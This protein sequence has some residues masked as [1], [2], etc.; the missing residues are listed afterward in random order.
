MD[1]KILTY[2]SDN[3]LASFMNK[4]KWREL[5]EAFTSHEEFEPKVRLKYR[6]DGNLESGFALQDWEWIKFGGSS[7]IEWM[8]RDPIKRVRQ[9]QL[10]KDKDYDF[11]DFVESTLESLNISY[12]KEGDKYKV[13]GY[14]KTQPNFVYTNT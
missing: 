11:C 2:I 9:G 8:D 10:I 13:W 5:A 1:A 14:A 6:A 7:C 3:Q 4:T 12:S